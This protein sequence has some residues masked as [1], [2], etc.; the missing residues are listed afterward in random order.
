MRTMFLFYLRYPRIHCVVYTGDIDASGP[1]ILQKAVQRFNITIKPVEFI[2]LHRRSLV[3]ASSYPYFTL[4]GQ[5]LG[6]MVLGWEAMMKFVPDVYIDTMGYAF[7]MPLFK[8]LAGVS[9]MSYVH[10]PTI[11]TD[12]LQKVA[13]RTQAHNNA[14]FISQSAILSWGKLQYY[15]MF[16]WL[17]GVMG[18]RSDKI[19]VNSTWTCNHI[20][21]L[22][23]APD[24]TFIVYPP[25]DVSEFRKIL[26]TKSSASKTIISIAQ[27]RPEKD[28]QL[29][30]RSFY[31]FLNSQAD[32]DYK[33]LLVGSCRNEGDSSRVRELQL[34]CNKLNLEENVEFKLNVSFED[35][36]KLM[37]TSAIGIHTMWNEHFGIGAYS[38][39]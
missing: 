22:W 31:K 1:E 6:S 8:L 28:H 20:K 18:R 2:F 29:Q 12:M 9:T 3:E 37:S 15:K 38:F 16:A 35:L 7:T 34:L 24:R 17:Y 23:K 25:C 10:Y 4:L 21:Q 39:R 19:F 27:F 33:L 26:L 13:D 32:K 14:S 11:S 36:K 5:S 30:V